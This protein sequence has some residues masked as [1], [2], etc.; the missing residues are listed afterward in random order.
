MQL[1][2]WIVKSKH[3]SKIPGP[4]KDFNMGF[5]GAL[6]PPFSVY[7]LWHKFGSIHEL[8]LKFRCVKPSRPL[9]LCLSK[10]RPNTEHYGSFVIFMYFAF[11]IKLP[12]FRK[13]TLHLRLNLMCWHVCSNW[14][15]KRLS[16]A[17]TFKLWFL[18]RL[19][20]PVRP[21]IEVKGLI[22]KPCKT[23]R[24]HRKQEHLFSWR[25]RYDN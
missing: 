4:L 16:E 7:T 20:N 2:R 15:N 5:R 1:L 22:K 19:W 3:L 8:N 14:G 24:F 6:W 17:L 23:F 10:T 25:S 9:N 18:H 12:T 13:L 21:F 11:R